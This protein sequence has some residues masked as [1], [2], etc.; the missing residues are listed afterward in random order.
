MWHMKYE[1]WHMVRGEHSLKFFA[2][3]LLRFV[4]DSVLKILEGWLNNES[5]NEWFNDKGVFRTAPATP[6][7]LKIAL[8]TWLCK[9]FVNFNSI[10]KSAS[11]LKVEYIFKTEY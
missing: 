4:K 9:R 7:L 10:L 8:K 1:T 3:Q 11:H 5:M 6:G 2:P